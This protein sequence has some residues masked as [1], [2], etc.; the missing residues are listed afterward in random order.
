MRCIFNIFKINILL[1]LT[2]MDRLDLDKIKLGLGQILS[3]ATVSPFTLI[4]NGGLWTV[5]TY[6]YLI[7]YLSI[8]LLCMILSFGSYQSD[9]PTPYGHR[10]LYALSAGLWNILYL[11]YFALFH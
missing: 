2:I 8:F 6:M 10:L 5:T 4:T 3:Q 9:D 1:L 11:I 7:V